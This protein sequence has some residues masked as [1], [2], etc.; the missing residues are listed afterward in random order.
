MS[1]AI[2]VWDEDPDNEFVPFDMVDEFYVDYTEAPGK[3]LT[4]VVKYGSRKSNPS[5]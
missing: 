5:M 3:A 1:V 4:P 2:T